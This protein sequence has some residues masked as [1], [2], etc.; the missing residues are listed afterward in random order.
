M[1]ED[2]RGCQFLAVDCYDA[3]P[4]LQE[5]PKFHMG[6]Q[7]LRQ[8]QSF[9]TLLIAFRKDKGD[10]LCAGDIPR[11]LSLVNSCN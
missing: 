4:C 11:L 5:I 7:M 10:F 8:A 9:P 2:G 1:Y 3:G 6:S